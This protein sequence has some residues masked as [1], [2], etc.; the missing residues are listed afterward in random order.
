[1]GW[2][3][4][5]THLSQISSEQLEQIKAEFDVELEA[6]ATQQG[7]WNDGTTFFAFGRKPAVI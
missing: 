6:L 2:D 3:A 1:M 4:G 7:I 5:Q